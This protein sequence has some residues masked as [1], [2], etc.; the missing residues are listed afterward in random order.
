MVLGAS[1]GVHPHGLNPVEF[2]ELAGNWA[3]IERVMEGRLHLF[4]TGR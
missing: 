3:F 1:F 2:L 4:Q